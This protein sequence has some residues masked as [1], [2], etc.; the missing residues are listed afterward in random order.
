M[1]MPGKGNKHHHMPHHHQQQHHPQQQQLHQA[2]HVVNVN[3][4]QTGVTHSP[5]YN[6]VVAANQRFVPHA[7][8]EFHVPGQSYGAQPGG[9][10]GGGGG[11]VGVPG[12]RGPPLGGIQSIGQTQTGIPP[13]GPAGGQQPPPQAQTPGVQPQQPQGPTP[14]TTPPVHTPSP[15]EMGKQGHLQ[16][17][18]VTNQQR[19][20][21]QAYYSA[22]PR[23]QQPRGMNHR[24]GQ[25]GGSTQVI[26]MGGAPSAG[27]QQ[28]QYSH[29]NFPGMFVQSQ[30]SNLQHQHQQP[31]NYPMSM[32][33]RPPQPH[34]N[35]GQS[36]FYQYPHPPTAII[37]PSPFF[38]SQQSGNFAVYPVN[39]AFIRAA[40]ANAVNS[41]AQHMQGQLTNAQGSTVVPQGTL[42]QPA[43]QPQ[44]MPTMISVAPS[45]V[46]TGHNGGASGASSISSRKQR[47]AKAIEIIHPDTGKSISE[48]IY[49]NES[50]K[51]DIDNRE[52]PQMQNCDKAVIADFAAMVAKAATESSSDSPVASS[53]PESPS[54]QITSQSLSNL[55]VQTNSTTNSQSNTGP[56]TPTQQTLPGALTS[57]SQSL[58]TSSNAAQL[59][60]CPVKVDSKPLQPLIKEFQPRGI[61]TM[62]IVTTPVAEQF[63]VQTNSSATAVSSS[64]TTAAAV[65][66]TTITNKDNNKIPTQPP[67]VSVVNVPA[68]E[69]ELKNTNLPQATPIPSSTSSSNNPDVLI[70]STTAVGANNNNPVPTKDPF[71]NLV[72]KNKS[73]S[74]PPSRRKYQNPNIPPNAITI[75]E[76]P[77]LIKESKEQ[78]ERKANEKNANS[79]G[80][81]PTPVHNQPEHFH[82]KTNGETSDKSE[83]ETL[84]KNET[85]QK[86]LDGK[87][88]M[89]KQK[90]KSKQKNR[91]IS[92]KGAEKESGSDMDAFMNS[93]PSGKIVENKQQT[94]IKEALPQRDSNKEPVKEITKDIKEKDNHESKKE[95]QQQQQQAV[96]QTN[97]TTPM[98]IP[99]ENTTSVEKTS[100][101]TTF[102]H[103][104]IKPTIEESSKSPTIVS[105]SNM[106]PIPND[107]VDH[108]VTIK[109]EIDLKLIVAQKNEEN[110]KVSAL[111]TSIE[112]TVTVIEKQDENA[113]PNQIETIPKGPQLLKYTYLVD[114]WSPINQKGK[115]TY[116]RDFLMQLQEDPH[117]KI[118]PI[119][120]PDLDVVL[121]DG[122]KIRQHISRNRSP[123]MRSFKDHNMRG[124]DNLLPGFAKNSMNAK[125][126]GLP[127]ANKKS[128]PG[129]PRQ[130]NKP[131][132][133]MPISL[134]LREEV[135]LRESENAW[136]PMM[137]LKN[138]DVDVEEAKTEV[139]CKKVRS[140]LNK[141]TPQK[142][143]T[144]VGQVRALNIDTKERMERV[145][146]LVFEKAIDEPSF[147]VEYALMCKELAMMQVSGTDQSDTTSANFRKLIVTRCQTEFQKESENGE[148]RETKSKEI[149][150]CADPDKKKELISFY[151]EEERRIR[152]K[153]VGNIR[154][155]GELFKQGMLTKNIMHF[156]IN[157]LLQ[158]R[159]EENL[160][161]LCKLLTTIGKKLE[162]KDELNEHFK[163][164]QSIANDKGRINSRVRF[165]LKDVIDLRANK[166]V[167]RRDDSNPKTMDQ[168]QREAETERLDAQ[169][170][171]PLNT[172]RKDD[173]NV[174]RRRNRGGVGSSEDGGWSQP[175][176]TSRNTYSCDSS[177]LKTKPP[178][179][180]DLQLGNRSAYTMWNKNIPPVGST[181]MQNKFSPLESISSFDQ[182]KRT[183]LQLSG[184]KSMGPRE[185]GRTDYKSSYDGR[186]SR[187]GSSYPL[188]SSG[189]LSREGISA[190]DSGRS[191]SISMPP[192]SKPAP[193]PTSISNKPEK[194][195]DELVKIVD[196]FVDE[197]I[198]E[199]NK[200]DISQ[201]IRDHF[202]TSQL[203]MVIR[204]MIN[205][206]LEKSVTARESISKLLSFLITKKTITL[207]DVQ[208]G[209][210]EVL[211][212]I[213]DLIID[214]PKIWSYIADILVH[215]LIDETHPFAELPITLANLRIKGQSGKF[216]GELFSKVATISG[217]EMLVQKWLMSKLQFSDII[218]GE[219]ENIDEI[220]KN[221][222]LQVLVEEKSLTFTLEQ[223]QDYL[224]KLMKTNSNSTFDDVVNWI[225]NNVPDR[226]LEP[227]F[228][229]VLMTAI[230]EVSTVR[231]N[232][233]HDFKPE[234]FQGLQLL[235]Q[236]FV[237]A[238]EKLE[239][240]CLFAVQS[241]ANKLE[242]PSGLLLNIFD[243]L[244]EDNIISFESF[245]SWETNDDATEREGKAVALKA[246]TSF[247]TSLKEA[248]E[249]SEEETSAQVR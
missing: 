47:R 221:Y 231:N 171:V 138:Q 186:S 157:H 23:P 239:L 100:P 163:Q 160:E 191:Q 201:E 232:Q 78:R 34:H 183:P 116:G 20:S 242:F 59:E 123:E 249:V 238:N 44:P 154:F 151:E 225:K 164:M 179:M 156:C 88:A 18:F 192:Q 243:K 101:A 223:I 57:H 56:P 233:R 188:S 96:P 228:I 202:P 33:L 104:D 210:A 21:S 205:A 62:K 213:D 115:K 145:I 24:G 107:V 206:V 227:Q 135:K 215:L 222:K 13:G 220:I 126:G 87:S 15:Q 93:V 86:T 72:N 189:S 148:L 174:D 5:Q 109:T 165:M 236:R 81:T 67:G 16:T 159:D 89:Q 122:S 167:P 181:K 43:Q 237:D 58:G 51:G 136:K 162:S 35:Q 194:S 68:S 247:F 60:S 105:S 77:P 158:F 106:S 168:I 102:N 166:W 32:P 203:P 124:H 4:N 133:V 103:K 178:S 46:F 36:P 7:G 173:R 144:L 130:P 185:C 245:I 6:T 94:D 12:G 42:Q 170:N 69:V 10:V 91:E 95:K 219:R 208:K 27:A 155:I 197:Y 193:Q 61:D 110:S 75:P 108:S 235:I 17:V 127:P 214:I 65:A 22:G 85:Q 150:E 111:R 200:D 19:P 176:R 161:C 147:S 149:D 14:T 169:L 26:S 140:V 64:V 119:N 98:E 195:E 53:A 209:L 113:A 175:V 246:L 30:L 199:G 25:G 142:F 172:P 204:Q 45:E 207:N 117:S 84:P 128:N 125:M 9:Q 73:S 134:S 226:V 92:R 212:C 118:K 50:E 153:S 48:E 131:N 230:L 11:N 41:N 184:S 229:R 244:C 29:H 141:L 241:F 82:Q 28:M 217:P 49:N 8:S 31:V 40:S 248:E 211:E 52:A 240:Q 198:A 79:R 74:S 112:E 71:P 177:K 99:M 2:S 187:N 216:V 54:S 39:H 143:D 129:K 76:M 218:N 3:V 70:P 66:T 152:M 234:I 224:V 37:T 114:Q 121:K 180:D 146:N 137:R 63:H 90:N 190:L 182:E 83:I 132:M 80:T 1:S 38:Y 55:K 139:L 97:E 120:L 196:L